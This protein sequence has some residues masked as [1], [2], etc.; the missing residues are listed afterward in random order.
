MTE[1]NSTISMDKGEQQRDEETKGRQDSPAVPAVVS[2]IPSSTH[3]A[4][5]DDIIRAG[6]KASQEHKGQ[7]ST[8]AC[9]D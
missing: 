1:G 6:H 2:G 4:K 3:I 7:H 8:S 5:T 9:K